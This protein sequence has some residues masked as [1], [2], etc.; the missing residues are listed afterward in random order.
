MFIK[1]VGEPTLNSPAISFFRSY[2]GVCGF[3]NSIFELKLYEG[4]LLSI[5][6]VLLEQFRHIWDLG[7]YKL[8]W[9]YTKFGFS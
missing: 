3:N 7:E 6:Q 5:H 4:H 1:M 2:Y 8:S 9:G